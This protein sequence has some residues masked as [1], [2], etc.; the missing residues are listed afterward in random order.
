M[1][2][3]G[4]LLCLGIVV[5]LTADRWWGALRQPQHVMQRRC[6]LLRPQ[7]DSLSLLLGLVYALHSRKKLLKYRFRL[8]LNACS[9]SHTGWTQLM[10]LWC[11]HE[12]LQGTGFALPY[13]IV[14]AVVPAD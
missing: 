5:D 4:L 11:Q 13:G 1:E 10:Q 8:I 12:A 3:E 9:G 7:V 2:M 14:M 6:E